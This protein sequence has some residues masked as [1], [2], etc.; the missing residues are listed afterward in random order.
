MKDDDLATF[1]NIRQYGH[2]S[3][4]IRPWILKMRPED[5][6]VVTASRK[7]EIPELEWRYLHDTLWF[8]RLPRVPATGSQ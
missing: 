2:N 1:I 7:P 5:R 4:M 3:A 6:L 8:G